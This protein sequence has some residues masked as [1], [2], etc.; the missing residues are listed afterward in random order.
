LDSK[1]CDQNVL[2][3]SVPVTFDEEVEMMVQDLKRLDL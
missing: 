3:I 1:K 2:L